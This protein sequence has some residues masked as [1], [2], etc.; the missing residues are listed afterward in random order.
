MFR[1]VEQILGL[2]PQNQYA[3]AAQPMFDVFTSQRD[4]TPYTAPPNQIPLDEMNP[5]L[6]GLQG[7]QREMAEFSM[8][9][10]TVVT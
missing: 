1:T 3:L 5:A 8:T 6:A 7:R 10:D 4:L 2:P 9:I